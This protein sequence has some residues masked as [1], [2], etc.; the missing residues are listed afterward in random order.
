MIKP[1]YKDQTLFDTTP[2]LSEEFATQAPINEDRIR[3][4]NKAIYDYLKTGK[5]LT[6]MQA[7]KRWGITRLGARCWDLRH[8]CNVTIYDRMI[9]EAGSDVK[10]Y[11]INPFKLKP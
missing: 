1:I 11:S 8:I 3:G 7:I 4:Q 10:E 6:S 9:K 2:F 5:T